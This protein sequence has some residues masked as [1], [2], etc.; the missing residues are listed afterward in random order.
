MSK[1]AP[2]RNG[3]KGSKETKEVVGVREWRII[4]ED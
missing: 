4:D 3:I 1:T 2:D